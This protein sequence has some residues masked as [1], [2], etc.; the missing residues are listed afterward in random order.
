M[1]CTPAVC[2]VICAAVNARERLTWESRKSESLPIRKRCDFGE[3]A[4]FSSADYF[5]MNIAVCRNLIRTI[6][7]TQSA[8]HAKPHV[9]FVNNIFLGKKKKSNLPLVKANAKCYNDGRH[10]ASL[11]GKGKIATI[12][13]RSLTMIAILGYGTSLV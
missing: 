3:M 11:T 9:D 12:P 6:D 1:P 13:M 10:E 8:Y 2:S 4:P 5:P 7:S